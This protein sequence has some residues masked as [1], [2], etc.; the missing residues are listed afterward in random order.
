MNKLN[1]DKKQILDCRMYA[2]QVAFDVQQFIAKHSTV[3]VERTVLR[4]LGID[5]IDEFGVPLPNKIV[6]DI[7]KN[8]NI[9]IGVS[10]YIASALNYLNIESAI[11]I[12]EGEY[13]FLSHC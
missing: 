10:Y 11:C 8:G 5:G 2:E 1:L 4:L 7:L 9:Q 3:S 6:D 13:L 12:F